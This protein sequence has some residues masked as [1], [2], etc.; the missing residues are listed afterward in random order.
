MRTARPA[1]LRTTIFT[2]EGTSP[3]REVTL[4]GEKSGKPKNLF[5]IRKR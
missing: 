3:L 5:E 4:I 2:D 1:V